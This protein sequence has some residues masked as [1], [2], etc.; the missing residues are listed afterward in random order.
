M[1]CFNCGNDADMEIMIMVNGQLKKIN[2]CMDCY[3]EQMA[4]MVDE[5]TDE[6]GNI[7]PEKIQ[8]QMFEFFENNKEA[9]N[10]LFG[11]GGEFPGISINGE[12][13]EGFSNIDMGAFQ[14]INFDGSAEGFKNIF[15]KNINKEMNNNTQNNRFGFDPYKDYKSKPGE[16]NKA[17]SAQRQIAS[18]QNTL[19]EKKKTLQRQ[20]DKEDYLAAATSRDEIKEMNRRIIKLRLLQKEVD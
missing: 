13:F 7:D 5:M 18:I 20:I 10:Q 12:S 19:Q 2:I 14:N 3:R 8:K 16:Y 17:C 15:E 9:F 1:Q 11:E 4:D 6:N